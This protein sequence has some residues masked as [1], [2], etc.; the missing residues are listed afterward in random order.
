MDIHGVVKEGVLTKG[1]PAWGRQLQPVELA[2]VVAYVGT[3]RGKNVPGKPPEGQ[4]V[5]TAAPSGG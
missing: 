4:K 1:M 3:L 2:K 5:A